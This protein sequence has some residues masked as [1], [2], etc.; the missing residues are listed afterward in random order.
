MTHTLGMTLPFSLAA[1]PLYAPVVAF[2]AFAYE[3]FT[4]HVATLL[5]PCSCG[6]AFV[7]SLPGSAQLGSTTWSR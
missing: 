1:V 6:S 4:V 2:L 3:S 5:G 7:H